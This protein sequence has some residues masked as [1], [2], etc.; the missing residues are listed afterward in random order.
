LTTSCGAAPAARGTRVPPSFI[1]P[2]KM[3]SC[4][5]FGGETVFNI[6]DKL[7]VEEDIPIDHPM[8]SKAIENAQKKVEARNF[9]IR[10]HVLEYDDVMNQQREVIYEQRRRV[11][12]GEDVQMTIQGMIRKSSTATWTSTVIPV[13]IRKSGILRALSMRPRICSCLPGA[14]RK[15]NWR[16]WT[17]KKSGTF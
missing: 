9:D 16:N 1:S 7:G 15:K 6:M 11:L 8:I 3:T 14:C 4:A 17:G 10:K 13:Y 2:W 5:L 12:E